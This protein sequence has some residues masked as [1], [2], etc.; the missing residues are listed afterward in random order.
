[1]H[2]KVIAIGYDWVQVKGGRYYFWWQ[3]YTVAEWR[4]MHPT[5]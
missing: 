5:K 1:M 3:I 2:G 4:Q